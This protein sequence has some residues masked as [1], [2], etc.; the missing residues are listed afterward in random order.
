MRRRPKPTP[1]PTM[2][3]IMYEVIVYAP[4]VV[5][6]QV[7]MWKL[8]GLGLIILV[9]I[10]VALLIWWCCVKG[11]DYIIELIKRPKKMLKDVF[12]DR[13]GLHIE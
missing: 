10:A 7:D 6:F 9:I 3:V 5:P 1:S 13:G 11:V 12:G 4:A 8:F 2:F